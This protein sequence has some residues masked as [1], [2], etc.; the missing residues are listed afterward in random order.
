MRYVVHDYSG[1]PF[2]V[3]LSRTLAMRGHD[4]THVYFADNHGPKGLFER[5]DDPPSLHYIGIKLGPLVKQTALLARRFNDLKYGR[6]VA[7]IIR[8]LSPDAVLTGNAPPDAQGI[9]ITTCRKA[10]IR[11]VYWLQ[12]IY[13][14]A[15]TK[16]VAQ[17]FGIVGTATI[18]AYYQWLDR[19][20]FRMCDAV[21]AI[22]EDF[23][24]YLRAWAPQTPI[25]VIENWGAIDDIPVGDKDNSW[26]RAHEVHEDFTFLYSGTLGRKH[27]PMLL[28]RLAKEFGANSTVLAVSQGLGTE[29]LK[30]ANQAD[31]HFALK[32]LPLQPAEQLADVLASADVLIATIETDAGTFA[33]PSKVQSYLCSGRPI[34]LAASKDNLAAR[35]VI[36]AEAG[37][38]VD[39]DDEEAFVAAARRL[40]T[41]PN[42]R[43]RLA[44]NGRAYA[45]KTFDLTAITD[46]FENVLNYRVN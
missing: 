23:M 10:G 17:K 18:G 20:Q 28:L 8:R 13:G 26:S 7:K 24:P 27:N 46:R 31:P 34:L 25:T 43:Q 9:I 22:T 21:V 19:R 12:D 29:Q 35:T 39:P 14:I 40:R 3:H 16:L 5:P 44:T 30:A 36:R 38:V 2:Q 45:Q 37:I 42:L 4:V 6:E 11:V 1:H 32:L 33:V 15:I 41:S